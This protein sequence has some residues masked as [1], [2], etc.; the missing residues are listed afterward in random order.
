MGPLI[1]ISGNYIFL[2]LHT[3]GMLY[4]FLTLITVGATHHIIPF[5][6]WW[7]AYAPKIGKEKAPT[8]KEILPVKVVRRVLYSAH[9]S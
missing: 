2:R 7:R 3:D 9:L 6:L 4:G 5:L 1:A 8:L